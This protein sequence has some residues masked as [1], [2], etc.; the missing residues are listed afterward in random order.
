MNPILH[1]HD[2][3]DKRPALRLVHLPVRPSTLPMEQRLDCAEAVDRLVETFGLDA[4]CRCIRL[5]A[6]MNG[7]DV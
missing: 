7:R 3:T 1:L 5:V 2:M 6:A 4:V